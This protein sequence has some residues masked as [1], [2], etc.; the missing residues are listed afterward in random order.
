MREKLILPGAIEESGQAGVSPP[1]VEGGDN[2]RDTRPVIDD[3]QPA[4]GGSPAITD[5]EL[6]LELFRAH[7]NIPGQALT[8]SDNEMGHIEK[9]AFHCV[10]LR[11][12]ELLTPEA[13]PEALTVAYL[14]GAK[15]WKARAEKAEADKAKAEVALEVGRAHAEWALSHE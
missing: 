11:A 15:D 8:F 3:S 14:A 2:R 10:A 1:L 5:E 13:D 4:A 7:R 12:R 6:G 9:K